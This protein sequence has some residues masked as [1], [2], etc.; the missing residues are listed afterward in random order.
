M[1]KRKTST[2]RYILKDGKPVREPDLM[3][4]AKW[5]GMST[6]SSVAKSLLMK[7]DCYVSTVFTGIDYSINGKVPIFWETMV[8]GGPLDREAERCSGSREQAE[9]MHHRMVERVHEAIK[10]QKR[11][12]KK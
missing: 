11:K 3:K 7:G 10:E 12:D 5:M 9:A 2:R 6:E 4:W 1:R 8:F